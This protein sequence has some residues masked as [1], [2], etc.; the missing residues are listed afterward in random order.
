VGTFHLKDVNVALTRTVVVVVVGGL[1]GQGGVGRVE[2]GGG[3]G[4]LALCGLGGLVK[5]DVTACAGRWEQL[6]LRM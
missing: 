4:G 3:S 1:R 5:G 2:C 6:L